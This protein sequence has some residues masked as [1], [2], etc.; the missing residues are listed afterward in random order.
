MNSVRGEVAIDVAG[1]AY[2]L[3][4]STNALVEVENIFDRPMAV[5]NQQLD[6]LGVL[7]V[8]LWAALNCVD[9]I[10]KKPINEQSFSLDDVGNLMDAAGM[11][12]IG[13]ALTKALNLAF[14]KPEEKDAEARP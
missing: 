2:K 9:P 14:P 13:P 12:A 4:F 10:T 5:I 11:H 1:K 3:K 7:R 8:M 6:R